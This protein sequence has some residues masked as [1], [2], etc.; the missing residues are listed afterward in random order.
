V[1]EKTM[2]MTIQFSIQYQTAPGQEI[3]LTGNHP[4]LGNQ[5]T[6][7]ALRMSYL[8][9]NHWTVQVPFKEKTLAALKGLSYRYFVLNADGT[10]HFEGG[11]PRK[12]PHYSKS[13]R[14]INIHDLW[15]DAS[16]NHVIYDTAPF[17]NAFLQTMGDSPKLSRKANVLFVARWP[18]LPEHF[19]VALLG[20]V[21]Q[22]HQWQQERPLLLTP[23]GQGQHLLSIDLPEDAFP[24]A[25][26][27][28]IYD[29]KNKRFLG[30]EE[31]DNR[32]L[33][34]PASPADLTI[35][36]DSFLRIPAPIW[37]G[38]GVSAPVFSLRSEKSLGVGEFTD[39][40]LLVDWCVQTG[41]RLIQVLPV[42]DTGATKTWTDS[43]PYAAIS[44]FALHP[45]YL[46]LEEL[47][48][49][50]KI[51]MPKDWH[52][53]LDKSRKSLNALDA[54]EYEGVNEAKSK[55]LQPLLVDAEALNAREEG[56]E[57]FFEENK[58]WLGAYAAFCYFRDLYGTAKFAEWP[59]YNQ[60]DPEALSKYQKQHSEFEDYVSGVYFVQYHLH[61]QL[62]KAHQYALDKGVAF[63]GDVPIGIYRHSADAWQQPDLYHMD[64]Q[65]GAP[66]DDF[67]IKGQNWGFPTYNWPRMAADG[68]KWW[69]MRF[70]QM[71]HYYDAFRIDHILGFF[72]IW[73]IP[74]DA[75]E[76]I[77]GYFEPAI[78]VRADEFAQ[79]GIPLEMERLT[80]P[81]IDDDVLQTLFGAKTPIV[82][83]NFLEA[84]GRGLFAL[85]PE[86][87]TQQQVA[88]FFAKSVNFREETDLKIGLYD[89]ISNVILFEAPGHLSQAF[90]FRFHMDRTLSF[91]ALPK[92][93]QDRLLRLYNDYFFVRQDDMWQQEALQ[94]LPELVFATDMLVC[95]E[96]LGLV[97]ACVP[98]V[99]RRLGLLS[100]EVQ[101]MPKDP[102]VPFLDLT[103][104]PYKSVATPASHDTSTIRGWWQ[105][106]ETNREL[107]Y[108][109]HLGKTGT[110][111]GPCSG[112]VV[113]AIIENHLKSPSMWAIFQLQDWVGMDEKLRFT[114]AEAE[115]IN[116]PANPKH[117]WRWRFHMPLEQLKKEK[118]FNAL[119]KSMVAKAGR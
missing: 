115:R 94:K 100:L 105:E 38:A 59:A 16:W 96:D 32:T 26:K 42:N 30:F 23:D 49:Y 54:V 76:G 103:Q 109:H 106:P 40:K 22:L 92:W 52:A 82:I 36:N 90:H 70:A 50:L 51:K 66:P 79:A 48:S 68:F 12:L 80:Q 61:R 95:G 44:A 53:S 116:V 19:Q 43:Y 73:S 25:Y 21:D 112:E 13:A 99:M 3:Y 37:K 60:Y 9:A 87:R 78:P 67:A 63:K 45:M 8:D 85:K 83:S 28:G 108:Q 71:R 62:Q 81:F 98:D 107:L 17:R 97:P 41:I 111:P 10:A 35:L 33:F 102:G 1:A 110:P 74:M 18:H 56:F 6:K 93:M 64:R 118:A 34:L 58:A 31:G 57:V 27:Y 47:V 24:F 14:R 72:R 113:Q 15:T 77:M 88:Q 114:D 91:K 39:L 11:M 46:N 29:N 7:M 86:F 119:V 101:R 69:Q 84:K 104:V 55:L 89:L 75:V 117:Y 4:L 20:S 5:N 2:K 65:A